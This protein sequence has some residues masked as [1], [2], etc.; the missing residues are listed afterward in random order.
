NLSAF[1]L[2]KFFELHGIRILFASGV[3]NAGAALQLLTLSATPSEYSIVYKCGQDLSDAASITDSQT[4]NLS[5]NPTAVVTGEEPEDY[6]VGNQ[7]GTYTTWYF[8]GWKILDPSTNEVTGDYYRAGETIDFTD[9]SIQ[10]LLNSDNQLVLV[11]Q[12]ATEET[13]LN[14]VTL[15]VYVWY[16]QYVYDS[17]AN[18]YTL[19]YV[20]SD[21]SY[22]VDAATFTSIYVMDT[23]LYETEGW[24]YNSS[25]STA[26]DDSITV[27]SELNLYYDIVGAMTIT[28]TWMDGSA[29]MAADSIPERLNVTVAQTGS[30]GTVAYETLTL[31]KADAVAGSDYIWSTTIDDVPLFY[32]TDNGTT[33][34]AYEYTISEAVPDGYKE[35]NNGSVTASLS[36]DEANNVGTYTASLTNT[37]IR[38]EDPTG[39]TDTEDDGKETDGPTGQTD[40][41]DDGKE[42]EDPTGQTDA[43]DDGKET[44]DP[45]GQTDAEDDG[46]ETD[47]PT[48]PTDGETEGTADDTDLPAETVTAGEEDFPAMV[49]LKETTS[50]PADGKAYALGEAITYKLTLINLGNVTITN[51][52]VED[53][54]TGNSGANAWTVQSLASGE[55]AEFTASYTVTEADI[56]AG[57]VVNQATA[58]GSAPSGGVSDGTRGDTEIT[59]VTP[60]N[61]ENGRT[62]DKTQDPDAVMTL[63]KETTSTPANGETYA[64]GEVITYK[65]TVTNVG[66]VTLTDVEVEDELTGNTGDNV[67]TVD[68]IAPGESVELNVSYTVTEADVLSETV[69]NEAS[70]SAVAPEEITEYQNDTVIPEDP[71]DGTAENRTE[72]A[73]TA[74]AL[75]KSVTSTPENGSWYQEGET[76]EYRLVL[77]NTGNITLTDLTVQD[78]LTGNTGSSAWY[79][80]SL[81][82]GESVV[83]TADYTVTAEDEEAGTVTNTATAQATAQDGNATKLSTSSNR[84]VVPT[85]ELAAPQTGDGTPILPYTMLLLGAF[86]VLLAGEAIRRRK[87][88]NRRIRF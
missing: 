38:T 21:L 69:F 86:G 24:S 55:T 82:P 30:G 31:T 49:L 19:T 58:S 81:E 64:L 14:S 7:D 1:L 76:V 39:Q 32:S 40:A 11:A 36:I 59:L 63:V 28:K 3:E 17:S 57:S 27:A 54:L 5:G 8:Y 61:A 18:S 84:A 44:E 68:S 77:T 25:V 12:Y 78:E 33:F 85:N 70:A 9:S 62:E 79:A 80:A 26:S 37:R 29:A 56:L 73:R 41:E 4:Y 51:I 75:T 47:G 67:L 87:H 71:E 10:A 66:N 83:F 16:Q 43:E 13:Y 35:S 50:T 22:T 15:H 34:I 20:K 65:I 2:I 74:M 45:T 6:T 88:K 23:A 60:E 52:T 53:A 42:T 72:D 48:D 46:K